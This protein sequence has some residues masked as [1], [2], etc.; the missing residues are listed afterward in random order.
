MLKY[1]GGRRSS[2]TGDESTSTTSSSE[3]SSSWLDVTNLSSY[4]SFAE[5]D[6][7]SDSESELDNNIQQILRMSVI[8]NQDSLVDNWEDNDVKRQ[9]LVEILE[10]VQFPDFSVNLEDYGIRVKRNPTNKGLL[11]VKITRHKKKPDEEDDDKEAGK[12]RKRKKR[13]RAWNNR[14]MVQAKFQKEEKSL[15]RETRRF[16]YSV[17]MSK[18][19][20]STAQQRK[21]SRFLRRPLIVALRDLSLIDKQDRADRMLLPEISTSNLP[22]RGISAMTNRTNRIGGRATR[23]SRLSQTHNS[24]DN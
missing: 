4:P 13:K 16:Q 3:V 1:S 21:S 12:R 7:M 5:H 2:G 11:A 15:V 22:H 8:T 23:L 14:N 17:E 24:I 18:L 10:I 19:L 6:W 20:N 9:L